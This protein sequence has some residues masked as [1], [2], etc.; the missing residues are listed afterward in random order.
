M[1]MEQRIWLVVLAYGRRRILMSLGQRVKY[2]TVSI[3]LPFS[4]EPSVLSS[5]V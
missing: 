1:A 4:P 2:I 5:A 3:M